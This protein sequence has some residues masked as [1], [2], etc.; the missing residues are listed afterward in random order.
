[1]FKLKIVPFTFQIEREKTS[2][3][4]SFYLL[5]NSKILLKLH[6]VN[7]IIV[8]LFKFG[9][10]WFSGSENKIAKYS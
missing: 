9:S 7:L 10:D 1:M 8:K 2:R 4:A 6:I 5:C 3:D